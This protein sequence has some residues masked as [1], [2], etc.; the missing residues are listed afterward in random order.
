MLLRTLSSPLISIGADGGGRGL[1]A[2]D[3]AE[4]LEGDRREGRVVGSLLRATLGGRLRTYSICLNSS[5]CR[6]LIEQRLQGASATVASGERATRLARLIPEIAEVV[7]STASKMRLA[8]RFVTCLRAGVAD[9]RVGGVEVPGRRALRGPD[10]RLGLGDHRQREAEHRDQD[11]EEEHDQ[12]HT[13]VLAAAVGAAAGVSGWP[14][15][16]ARQGSSVR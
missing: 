5:P 8:S 3:H 16:M 4:L 12:V 6:S 14:G 9:P 13:A 2:D 1:A 15:G 11:Q 7:E 10:L